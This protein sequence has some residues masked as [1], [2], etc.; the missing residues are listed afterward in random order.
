[1][2]LEMTEAMK[3]DYIRVEPVVITH[4]SDS[5]I[6]VTSEA[7]VS[8]IVRD[9]ETKALY[10]IDL[11]GVKKFD[12][13][14]LTEF[15]WVVEKSSIKCYVELEDGDIVATLEEYAEEIEKDRKTFTS[16]SSIIYTG[17]EFYKG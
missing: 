4:K 6:L 14:V 11:G 8:A 2:K 17:K 9:L 1:M 3:K 13:E 12:H 15:Y 10:Y 16:K 5:D 7:N